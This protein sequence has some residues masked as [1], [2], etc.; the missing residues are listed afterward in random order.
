MYGGSKVSFC[1]WPCNHDS[2][3]LMRPWTGFWPWLK[4]LKLL[5]WT[6]TLAP[7]TPCLYMTSGLLNCTFWSNPLVVHLWLLNSW[8]SLLTLLFVLECFPVCACYMIAPLL[9]LRGI[10]FFH[11]WLFHSWDR[12][13]IFYLT[14]QNNTNYWTSFQLQQNS[15]SGWRLIFFKRRW[16]GSAG[17]KSYR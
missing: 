13:R 14:V 11:L 10:P 4:L 9:R 1:S 7:R 3:L 12:S 15:S 17:Q 2:A 5:L 16:R 6:L 8:T